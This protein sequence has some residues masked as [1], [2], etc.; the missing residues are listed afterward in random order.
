MR[1]STNNLAGATRDLS[2]TQQMQA[3]TQRYQIQADSD[4]A[5]IERLQAERATLSQP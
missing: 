5:E 1:L 3:V 4:R 2:L